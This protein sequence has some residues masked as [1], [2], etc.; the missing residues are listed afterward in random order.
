MLPAHDALGV[1]DWDLALRGLHPDD[2]TVTI[3]AGARM[4]ERRE[5]ADLLQAHE[6]EQA[7]RARGQALDDAREDDQR[8]AVADADLGDLLAEPHDEDGAGGQRE[9][10]HE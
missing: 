10:G 2:R 9:D 8:D 6:L 3:R 5:Q 4:R 7:H 1:L